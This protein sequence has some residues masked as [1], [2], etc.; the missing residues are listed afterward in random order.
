M[1]KRNVNEQ[2]AGGA[3]SIN[4]RVLLLAGIVGPLGVFGGLAEDI[5]EKENFAF[6]NP[7]LLF[8]HGHSSAFM[9]KVM[10]VITEAGSGPALCILCILL[11]AMLLMQRNRTGAIFL[12]SCLS[13]AALLN[14]ACK[15]LF[16]RA[17]PELWLSGLPE[18][19]FSFPSGHAMNSIAL[20]AALVI[21]FWPT[22]WRMPV[23][24]CTSIFVLLVGISRMYWGV[25]Y[26]SDIVAGWACGIAWVCSVKFLFDWRATRKNA[27]LR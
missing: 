11:T 1:E 22:R 27:G 2:N 15:H 18:T 17:R 4:R 7:T 16:G 19:S 25:H 24:A 6:D 14:Q 3:Q 10:T 20:C 13:G 26:P 21:I 9:D 5:V 12:A 23:L 8:L